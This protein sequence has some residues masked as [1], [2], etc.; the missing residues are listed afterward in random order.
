MFLIS[1]AVLLRPK[2]RKRI[3]LI[4]PFNR[5]V[6]I[7]PLCNLTRHKFSHPIR[8]RIPQSDH[9]DLEE[10]GLDQRS[11]EKSFLMNFRTRMKQRS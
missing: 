5:A 11:A 1:L 7:R 6:P 10:A 3:F 9:L 2:R 8:L 4:P